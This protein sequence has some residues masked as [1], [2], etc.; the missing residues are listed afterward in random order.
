[1]TKVFATS[2]RLDK[3]LLERIK[4]DAEK[5]GRSITKQIEYMLK[6]YYEAKATLK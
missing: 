5:E 4:T 3:E 1:M 2:V 6:K